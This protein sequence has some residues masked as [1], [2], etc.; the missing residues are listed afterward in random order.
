MAWWRLRSVLGVI[1]RR[2]Q[3][4]VRGP[5]SSPLPDGTNNCTQV[6]DCPDGNKP[7]HQ[8]EGHANGAVRLAVVNDRRREVERCEY[9]Q[10]DPE[11]CGGDCSGA[12]R[13]PGFPAGQQKMYRPP[14]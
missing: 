13:P 14:E 9:T 2:G 5:T 11:E 3:G 8:R 1:V 10:A 7:R 4:R 12:N 6:D